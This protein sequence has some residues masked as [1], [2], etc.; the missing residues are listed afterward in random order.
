MSIIFAYI[1]YFV[2]ASASPLQRR[3][4][5]KKKNPENHGQIAFAF[6]VTLVASI[7]SFTWLFYQP[8]HIQG[9]ALSLF[10]AVLVCGLSGALFYTLSFMAQKNVDLGVGSVI[11]NIYTPVT[12]ILATSFLGE[13]LTSIQIIGTCVLFLG[14]V[15][16]S[17][18][19]QVSQFR[20]DKYFIMMICA[21]IFLGVLT[22][23]ERFLQ[24][25]TGLGTGTI[26]SWWSIT[27]SL[28]I[29]MLYFKSKNSYSQKDILITGSLKFLQNVSWAV[30]VFLVGNLSFVSSVTTLKVILMFI[31]GAL[32]LGEKEDIKRKLFGSIIA[33]IGLL[34]MK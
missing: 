15:I 31:L 3:W 12:I 6:Y 4:L 9:N 33:V 26:M 2:A 7:L 17:K 10:F 11:A 16:V 25:T 5:A 34:L 8:F 20:F 21:G 28:G 22:V 32:F 1:F 23:A 29:C 30:L 27:V 19:H 14:I 18:K 24:K 13:S